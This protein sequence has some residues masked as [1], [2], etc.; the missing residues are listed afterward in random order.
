M[1]FASDTL[2]D[3]SE[4]KLQKMDYLAFRKQAKAL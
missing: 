1:N 3:Y 2:T 4:S